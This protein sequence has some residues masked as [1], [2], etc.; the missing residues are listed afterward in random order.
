MTMI[1]KLFSTFL[2]TMFALT[3]L[4]LSAKQTPRTALVIGNSDYQ[5]SPLVNPV[6]DAKDMAKVLEQAGFKVSLIINASQREMER[7]VRKFGKKLRQGGAGLFYYAG[8]GIQVKGR[9]YLVPIDAEIETESD[10]KYEAVDAGLILG[11]MEDAG[12]ALNIVILDACRNNPFARSFRSADR[13]LARMDAPKG[14]LIAYATSPGSVA[15]D[16]NQGNGV[17]TKHLIKHIKNSGLTIEQVLKRSRIAVAKETGNAQ[18]PWESSSLMGNFYFYPQEN[19]KTALVASVSTSSPRV[20]KINYEEEM[21]LLIKNSS[22]IKDIDS[23]LSSYPN[24]QFE[25]HARLKRNQLLHQQSNKT[26]KANLPKTTL[27]FATNELKVTHFRFF[28]ANETVPAVEDTVYKKQFNQESTSRIW[29]ELRVQNLKYNQSSQSHKMK[30]VYYEA[31]GSVS[32]KMEKD[33]TISAS[34]PYKRV[35]KGWG[36]KTPGNWRPG[37]YKVKAFIDD[38]EVGEQFFTIAQAKESFALSSIK[39]FESDDDAPD[40]KDREFSNNFEVTKARKIWT[41]VKIKNFRYKEQ[42][43]EHDVKW[44]YYK[45]N[46]EIDTTLKSKFNVKAQWQNAWTQKGWGYDKPGN[47]SPG[48][49]KVKVFIDDKE[50]A[51]DSFTMSHINEDYEFTSLKFFSAGDKAP[52]HKDKEY[53]NSFAKSDTARIWVELKVKNLQYENKNHEHDVEWTFYKP[54]N[55]IEGTMQAKFSIKSDWKSAW[56]H[57]GWGYKTTGNWKKG[58]YRVTVA[59]D[60][61]ETDQQTFEIN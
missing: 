28:S 43:H 17:Y 53:G 45:A 26:E 49:Y 56:I 23:F 10:V 24:G 35:S 30:W 58:T 60:G 3:S 48:T 21:W 41:E 38:M 52:E 40:S 18:I 27:N 47:W 11:K 59:I 9:N 33:F 37:R 54:D 19:N 36:W 16:G 20:N 34:T 22:N 14:S 6:N 31:D 7:S 1:N 25:Q 4:S 13:G 5:T 55:S 46:G 32:G 61:I 29:T 12:N 42:A 15:A 51:E 39:F 8:H 50:V 57:K 2:I 44:V